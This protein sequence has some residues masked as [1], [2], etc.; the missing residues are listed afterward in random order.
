MKVAVFGLG[1]IGSI[2]AQ[3]YE[4]DGVLAASWNRS[5][6]S[7]PRF[8]SDIRAAA[9]AADVLHIVVADPPAVDGL[10]RQI[11]PELCPGKLVIQSSTI[12]PAWA[13]K[14]ESLVQATGATYV[15]APFTGSKPA[16]ESRKLVFFIGGSP[17]NRTQAR[18]VLE[19]ISRK[20]FEL[21]SVAHASAIKLAMNLN[22]AGVAQALFESLSFA[23]EYHIDDDF[24]FSVLA[25]NVSH[26]G[27]SDLKKEKLLQND[28]SPQFSIK[29]MWKDLRLA[30]ESARELKIPLTSQVEQIYAKG[31]ENQ[32][33][34]ADFSA[35]ITLLSPQKKR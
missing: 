10:L 29:H 2:W 33:G 12:S 30:L 34:D 6:K 7:S 28:F 5:P 18:H 8:T 3:H 4:T 11:L 26:S 1:I 16:A 24:Y 9:A 13:E 20:F 35:L 21:E 22:I 31:A 25:E 19:K 27:V 32:L 23:R 15:E 17:A 14:N